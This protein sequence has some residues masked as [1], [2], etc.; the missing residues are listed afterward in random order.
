MPVT[1]FAII[2]NQNPN[3]Y[4]GMIEFSNLNPTNSGFD[5]A[6][7]IHC[8]RVGGNPNDGYEFFLNGTSVGIVNE[9]DVSSISGGVIGTFEYSNGI[10]TGLTDDVPNN[11]FNG[12][13]AILRL[14]N[15]MTGNS[16]NGIQLSYNYLLPPNSPH[17]Y[18]NTICLAYTS[19]CQPFPHSL[20]T[21]DTTACSNAPLQLGATGGIAYEWLPQTNL[22]CYDCPNPI[23][24]GDSTTNY[25]VRIWSTDSCSVVMPVRVRVVPSITLESVFGTPSLCGTDDGTL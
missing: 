20:L 8:D 4:S 25:T 19:P 23:F 24:T 7:S 10:L 16:L 5:I 2:L 14:N 13:D 15:Y 1:S 18:F 6:M 11:S 21:S 9:P 22:S 17:N 12:S 3:D